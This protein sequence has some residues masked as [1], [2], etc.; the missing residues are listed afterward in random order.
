M[1]SALLALGVLAAC[2]PTPPEAPLR[3][4]LVGYATRVAPAGPAGEEVVFESAQPPVIDADGAA[5]ARWEGE[6]GRVDLALA[7]VRGTLVRLAGPV[8]PGPGRLVVEG[9]GG[10]WT[11][12]ARWRADGGRTPRLAALWDRRGEALPPLLRA[13]AELAP[14]PVG[15]EAVAARAMEASLRA[16]AGEAERAIALFEQAADGARALG[17]TTQAVEHLGAAAFHQARLDDLAEAQ[18][19]VARMDALAAETDGRATVLVAFFDGLVLGRLDRL[20]R[21]TTRLEEAAALA[22]TLG[23][24]GRA[25]AA[26]EALAGLLADQ[27]RHAEARDVLA[28]L[29]PPGSPVMAWRRRINVAWQRLL[30][31]QACETRPDFPE[32]AAAF[33]ALAQ[34][35][36][37]LGADEKA[38]A[39]VNAAL[40]WSLAERVPAAE[41]ALA[42]A[43]AAHPAGGRDPAFVEH[44]AARLELAAGRPA[45]ARA[46]FAQA[47]ERAVGRTGAAG[48]DA[49]RALYGQ[50]LAE[51]AAGDDR[52]LGTWLRALDELAA[53]STRTGLRRGRAAW[54]ADRR[55][56]LE[57]ATERLLRQG[58][59]EEVVQRIERHGAPVRTRLVQEARLDGLPP[60]ASRRW[61]ERVAQRDH[62]RAALATQSAACETVPADELPACLAT[63]ARQAE[64]LVAAE[65]ALLAELDAAPAEAA[66]APVAAGEA[67]LVMVPAPSAPCAPAWS[68]VL[69]SPG[70]C[71]WLPPGADLRAT[72]AHRPGLRHLAV[73]DGGSPDARGLPGHLGGATVGFI[74]SAR[75]LA[76]ARPPATGPSLVVADPGDDLPHSR[77]T[78][79]ALPADVR[80]LGPAATRDAVLAHL[81][82]ARL[83]HFD[84]HGD[85]GAGDPFAAHI[86][87]AD[88]PLSVMDLLARRPRLG[89]VIL[90]GCDTGAAGPL[91][92]F[93]SLGLAEAFLLAGADRVIAPDRP[94]PDAEA[95]RFVRRFYAAGGADHPAEAFYA[96]TAALEAE[97]DGAGRGWRFFGRR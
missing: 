4:A 2:T 76:E 27:G 28:A 17:L 29:P 94:V 13:L 84:G 60:A 38:N 24:D 19:L 54:Y 56:L 85:L 10:A 90:S 80:L 11:I 53:A 57:V 89:T 9:R 37:A 74:P 36:L 77:A 14:P 6:G 40:G 18:R 65:G 21:A 88:G 93:E 32:V 82:G 44:L 58:E 63:Q 8:P 43:R 15:E 69:L 86:A 51:A 79:Q 30:S 95:A 42:A 3:V 70:A 48:D 91:S 45:E 23:D 55:A 71:E 5:R 66:A 46:A 49:W 33:E 1:R 96:T 25:A 78:G 81:D 83:F 22:T 50:G 52:A 31:M 34:A 73:A 12:T 67:V 97:G 16:R 59:C 61:A 47:H 68:G 39:W 75:W 64:Q 26:Q 41:A 87:L 62:A 20:S 7:P 35:P 92:R 72:L